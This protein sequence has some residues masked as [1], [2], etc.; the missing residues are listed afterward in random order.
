VVQLADG[1]LLVVAGDVVPL[2]VVLVEVVEHSQADLV[3]KAVLVVVAV[4]GLGNL[5]FG[6]NKDITF[7]YCFYVYLVY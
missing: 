5:C 1:R 3:L 4:V 7:L 6:P 2:D